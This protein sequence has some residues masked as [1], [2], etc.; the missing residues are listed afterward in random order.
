M[1]DFGGIGVFL[2]R[3]DFTIKPLVIT[4][5]AIIFFVALFKGLSRE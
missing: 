4:V 2:T 3:G 5:I 1:V